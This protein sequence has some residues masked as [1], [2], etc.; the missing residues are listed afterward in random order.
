MAGFV[1]EDVCEPDH[2]EPQP[3]VGS[4]P[5]RASFLPPYLRILARKQATAPTLALA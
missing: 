2:T 3:A 5:H 1:I 4:F